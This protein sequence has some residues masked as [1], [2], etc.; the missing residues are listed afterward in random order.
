MTE[1]FID[2]RYQTKML[3]DVNTSITDKQ[4]ILEVNGS[5]V[6]PQA[7][8]LSS[9]SVAANA[10]Y[11]VRIKAANKIIYQDTYAVLANRS[12]YEADMSAYQDAANNLYI[13]MFK[14]VSFDKKLIVEVY[15]STATFSDIVVKYHMRV[16]EKRVKH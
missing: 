7:L 9:D 5:G 2:D 8:F 13:S 11:G 14:N 10:V 1:I 4:T 3:H 15:G 16:D 6:M 12:N